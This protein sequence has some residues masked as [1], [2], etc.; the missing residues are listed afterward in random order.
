MFLIKKSVLLLSVLGVL[1]ASIASSQAAIVSTSE[2]LIQSERT[3]LVNML[4]RKDVQQQLIELGVDP[5]SS[6]MRV[7]QM[8]DEELAQLKGQLGVL[9][10]GAGIGTTDLLLIIILLVLLI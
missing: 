6:L 7:E 9:P 2:I 1:F 3:Q 8:T 4:E 5:E 10:A